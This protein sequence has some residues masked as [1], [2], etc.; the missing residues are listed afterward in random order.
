MSVSVSNIRIGPHVRVVGFQP[1]GGL[2]SRLQA[3]VGNKVVMKSSSRNVR[4]NVVVEMCCSAGGG[5]SNFFTFTCK[6]L[7]RI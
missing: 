3:G 1:G 5:I 7:H 2:P 4:R 6:L